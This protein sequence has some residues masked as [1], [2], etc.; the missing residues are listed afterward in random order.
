M[1]KSPEGMTPSPEKNKESR[2]Q[3]ITQLAKSEISKYFPGREIPEDKLTELVDEWTSFF[4][5]R[6]NAPSL[7]TD[8]NIAEKVAIGILNDMPEAKRFKKPEVGD[9]VKAD[10]LD[11]EIASG[12]AAGLDPHIKLEGVGQVNLREVYD[13]WELT[14]FAKPN[15]TTWGARIIEVPGEEK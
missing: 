1:P 6:Y 13:E 5:E 14:E 15:D 2:K 12:A 8:E 11:G 9:I 4:S 10:I 3:N 7:D